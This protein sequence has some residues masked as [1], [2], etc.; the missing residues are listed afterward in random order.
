M[1]T[2]HRGV[3]IRQMTDYPWDGRVTLCVTPD[4]GEAE[5]AVRLRI[6]S[7]LSERPVA[8]DLYSYATPT[9]ATYTLKVN[10]EPVKAPVVDGYATL[11]R[12]WKT[13]DQIDLELP[14]EVRR[15]R[16]NE[17]VE[18]DL[19]KLA[20][21]RG[22]VIYCLEGQDQADSTVF[23]KFI[24]ADT[25]MEAAYEAAL[26]N[27]VVV[28]TGTAGEV[29]QD[30]TVK[31]VPFRAIPYAT[32]N[33]RGTDQMAV[34]IPEDKEHARPTP[35]P[36]IASRAHT[37]MIQAPI[38][39]DAPESASIITEAWGVNDQWEPKRSSDIS[40]PYHY[41]WLK[42]GTEE[43]LAYQFDRP[44]EVKSVDVYWLDFDHYDGNFR[45]PE[46]WKLYYKTAAGS[47]KEVE[48]QSPY[49]VDRDRYNHVD[50][51]PVTTTGL[52]IAA[53]LQPGESGGIIEW[54]VD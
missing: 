10:G 33:N 48:A 36:T 50:F 29:G 41:W 52:K 28:L 7:W 11:K 53:K 47:W 12:T 18:D 16:A 40:K 51:T 20:I 24:P 5:F 32:W 2:A 8:T 14:M 1:Q 4:D 46:S 34:W 17:Q 19:G 42:E 44:T 38:Q 3:T 45:V 15:I 39:K 22:P 49:T 23:N 30:G 13:L 35:A 31:E 26:L 54:K 37:L 27:G 21:E 25:R 6:P 43:T 9:P